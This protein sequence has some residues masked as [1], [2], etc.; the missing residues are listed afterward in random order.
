[1]LAAYLQDAAGLPRGLDHARSLVELLDH[2]LLDVH[3]LARLHR[4]DRHRHVPVIRRRDDDGIDIRPRQHFPVVARR[5]EVSAPELFREREPS[6]VDVGNRHQ[7]DAR[8]LQRRA[9]VLLAA[10]ARADRGKAN[11]VVRRNALRSRRSLRAQDRR[12]HRR[13]RGDGLE[14][15]TS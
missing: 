8:R 10:N 7:L 11:P 12:C 13:A 5:E 9:H 14:K 6:F 4:V 15:I 2:R 3:V 1:V